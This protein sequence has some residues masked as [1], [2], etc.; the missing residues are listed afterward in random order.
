MAPEILNLGQSLPRLRPVGNVEFLGQALSEFDDVSPFVSTE[1]RK[2]YNVEGADSAL[3]GF[4]EDALGAEYF[5]LVNLLHGGALDKFAAADS[6][7]LF[8]DPNVE[9]L[10]RL[11]RLTGQVEILP[12]IDNP[13]GGNRYLSV[14]LEG[15]TG[16]LFQFPT[17][18]PFAMVPEPGTMPLLMSGLIVVWGWRRWPAATT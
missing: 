3:V 11:N 8:F 13:S 10:K 6:F 1:A 15:G 4:F 12:T 18:H 16:D 2:L 5:M 7:T 9:Y 14:N 17:D